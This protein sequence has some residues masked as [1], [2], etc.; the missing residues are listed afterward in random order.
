MTTQLRSIPGSE[1]VMPTGMPLTPAPGDEQIILSVHLR[2]IA[3]GT[4]IVGHAAKPREALRQERE[5][6][7]A[8]DIRQVSEFATS[9]GLTLV[10]VDAARRLIRLGGS[11]AALAQAF[12]ASLHRCDE[13]GCSYR[14]RTGSLHLPAPLVDRVL[15]V[16]GF[17]TRPAATPKIVPHRV[18]PVPK[19]FLPTEVAALYGLAGAKADETCIGIIELGGGYTDADN[20]AAFAAMG[21]PVPSIVAVPVD[22]GRNDPTDASG[23]NGEVALD[24]QVAGG[25]AVGA[26]L[27]V[28]FAANTDQ[29]FADAISQAVHDAVNKP[30]AISISWGSPESRWTGQAIAAMSAAIA[31]AATLGVT[32]TAASGDA[33]ATDGVA[34]GK[35]H[36]DYPA[37]DPKVLGCGG[38]R[39]KASGGKR[40]GETV[41][42][43]NGG[44]T[45]GGVSALFTTPSYQHGIAIP[46]HATRKG[47]RGVPD[48]AGNADPDSG[49]RIVTG[50]QVGI[51]GGTSAVAPFWA[52]IAAV[53]NASRSAPLG[54]PH[55]ALYAAPHA[56]HDVTKGDNK[57]GGIGY[58]AAAGWDPCTG[59]GTPTGTMLQSLL[60]VDATK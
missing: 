24:I 18:G 7:H 27:A 54:Q 21:L 25:V 12:G 23:A 17:D 32:V 57:S 48:V 2:P 8:D 33:L 37:S 49:Y 20:N 15:A 40:T 35:A 36:V 55:A 5:V 43:S 22:G 47:G 31:D 60:S 38:T 46:K 42:K 44:G 13:G 30:S 58:S 1:R 50:G 26:K 14:V 52:A 19:G 10:Q 39:I 29:G 51:I 45:G 34:D 4:D 41:W 53:I 9:N 56:L 28:Y 6:D 11:S 59:L 16:L 3:V